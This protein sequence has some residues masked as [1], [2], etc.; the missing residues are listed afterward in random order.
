MR[1]P[2]GAEGSQSVGPASSAGNMAA[3]RR[4][5]RD[6]RRD[7]PVISALKVRG[8]QISADDDADAALE[9]MERSGLEVR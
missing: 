9:I 8:F 5:H 7:H 1:K 3:E 2:P 4:R 6:R